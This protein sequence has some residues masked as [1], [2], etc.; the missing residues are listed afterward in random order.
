MITNFTA[1]WKK[2]LYITCIIFLHACANTS[3]PV[4]VPQWTS[5]EI[6]IQSNKQYN[7]PYTETEV[8]AWFVNDKGDSLVRPVFW[9]GGNT[10]KLRFAPPDA[11]HTWYWQVYSSVEDEGFEK[12]GALRSVPYTGNN[13]LEQHG[14]LRMSEGKRNII[15]ADGT[16]M[17]LVGDTPWSIPFRATTEQV[18]EYAADRRKKGFN[19][20]L[21]IGVQPDKQAEG[22]EARNTVEGFARGFYDIPQ[23]HLNQLN[24]SYFQTLDSIMS[25]LHRH[26]IVPVFA[27]LTHGYGWKGKGSLGPT[28]AGEEYAR[29]TKYLMARYGSSPALW[30]LSLDGHGNAP[31]VVPAGEILEKWDAYEQ[32]TGLH[33]N[34]CDDFLATWAV[35]DSS[36]CYHYN[37]MHQGA[38]WLDFQW[39]Q[40]G[41]DGKHLYHKVERMYDNKPVKAVMNGEPTYERMNEGTVGIGWWQGED[42]WNQLMHG[43]TMGVVYGAV[44]VWQWKIT[45]DEPGWEEWTNAPYNWKDALQFEGSRYVGCISRAFDG[46]DFKDMERR[47]DLTGNKLPLLAREGV[48]YISYLDKGGNISIKG[49]PEN[50]PCY[51]FDPVKGEFHSEGS[52]GTAG[53]FTAP[54]S[55]QPWVFIAG[56]RKK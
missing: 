53:S 38:A 40:T 19:T 14:L 31:G 51:W 5:Y 16:P 49:I 36:H 52:T 13:K 45:P 50:M 39:A 4:P 18:E 56:V 17:L 55:K 8:W 11:G 3:E 47:W 46:F 54:D 34:P 24:P 43:G 26:E 25:I 30:L 10:W 7:N 9:D 28:A 2:I 1:A 44:S 37:R 32:P 20:A 21:L 48:F 12:S 41:H 33:Y 29:Y 23:G 22:P 35:N 42:A 27:P 6:T 15:H